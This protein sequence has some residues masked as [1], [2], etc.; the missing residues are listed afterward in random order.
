MRSESCFGRRWSTAPSSSPLP[1]A[2]SL[3]SSNQPPPV[4][5]S[6]PSSADESLGRTT[7]EVP[8]SCQAP[9][10][11][12]H[13]SPTSRF[14]PPDVSTTS[15]ALALGALASAYHTSPPRTAP[16]AP[17]LSSG[18]STRRRRGRDRHRSYILRGPPQA[19]SFSPPSISSC[20][21]GA[22]IPML[23]SGSSSRDRLSHLRI[24]YV[25]PSS[26]RL[27]LARRPQPRHSVVY[28]SQA[29]TLSSARHGTDSPTVERSS[30]AFSLTRG[31]F[32]PGAPPWPLLARPSPPRRCTAA[33]YLHQLPVTS[34]HHRR[35]SPSPSIPRWF[36]SPR[37]QPAPRH[38]RVVSPV[39]ISSL[40]WWHNLAPT[41]AS[42]TH[43]PSNAIGASRPPQR[44]GCRPSPLF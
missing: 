23:C 40:V 21:H 32:R 37:S 1:P 33:L 29:A 27:L 6:S 13:R 17:V 9:H 41:P 22:S 26:P 5:D 12:S 20:R 2:L 25:A 42:G 18:S 10:R 30:P 36:P 43:R 31:T 15:P 7:Q 35:G 16:P 3:G 11:L 44:R 14:H 8:K 28:P 24:A 39:T 4:T 38:R 34:T 19:P